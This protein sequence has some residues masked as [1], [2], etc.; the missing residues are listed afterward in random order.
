MRRFSGTSAW[1]H[2]RL[3]P[4]FA[5]PPVALLIPWLALAEPAA[6]DL[7]AAA[8]RGEA[9]AMLELGRRSIGGDGVKRD[10]PAALRWF[11]KA[12]EAGLAEAQFELGRLLLLGRGAE[13]D[14]AGGIEF[15]HKAATAG[16]LPAQVALAE[17]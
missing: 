8:K 10:Q 14:P 12:A 7:N 3:P 11:R 2:M 9:W 15:L 1:N 6:V 4:A 5:V 17:A 13:S 16:W